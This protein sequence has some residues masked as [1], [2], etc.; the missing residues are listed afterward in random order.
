MMNSVKS[1]FS[2][3]LLLL[4]LQLAAQ[5]PLNLDEIAH[6]RQQALLPKAR[7]LAREFS[8]RRE[9]ALRL[10]K[11]R[12]WVIEEQLP[13]GGVMALQRLDD[14]GMPIYYI[15]HFNTRAAATI[16][17]Q[18]VWP[19]GRSNLNLSGSYPALSER[20]GIW[21]GGSVMHT[22]QEFVDRVIQQEANVVMDNHAT[23]VAGTMMAAGV[24]PLARG[25]AFGVPNIRS[26]SFSNHGD[27]MLGAA[28]SLLVSNHS[29]GQ[30]S[31]WR[32]NSARAG[33]SANP[34]WE[35]WG[36]TRISTTEDYAFGYY[37]EMSMLWDMIAFQSPQYLIVKSAGNNRNQTGP[38]SGAPFWRRNLQ[39]AWELIGMR[40]GEMSSNDGFDIISTYGNAKNILTVAAVNPI[41]NSYRREADVVIS[42]F[43]SFGPSDDGRIKPDISAN[44]VSLYSTTTAGN[45]GYGFMSGTSMS[46]PNVSGSLML[47]Q[48]KYHRLN[49][50]FMLS[51]TLRGLVCHTANE[52]GNP[53]PDYVF[54]WGLMNTERAAQAIQ[55]NGRSSLVEEISLQDGAVITRTVVASGTEPLVV[56]IAWIDPEAIPL[57]IDANALNNR[58]PRLINDLDVR[59]SDGT[60][61]FMPWVLDPN[62][63]SS[64]ATRGDN[65]L[66]NIEQI[67]IASPIPG[68]TYTI[69]ISHKKPT[70][71]RGTKIFSLIATGVGG[72]TVC[73]SGALQQEGARINSVQLG[74][75]NSVT[76]TGCSSYRDL[77]QLSARLSIGSTTP[78]TITTG[79]C[80]VENP[81]I[82]KL[83]ADWNTSGVFDADELV[84][85]SPVINTTGTFSGQIVVPHSAIV[86]SIVRLRVVLRETNHPDLVSA[87]GMFP[88]GETQDF[89]LIIE[90]SLRDIAPLAVTGLENNICARE[91]QLIEIVVDNK[92]TLTA[93]S[94]EAEARITENG[95]L[96]QT[97]TENLPLAVN[98]LS[99]M[100]FRF[101]QTFNTQPNSEYVV[102][103]TTRHTGDA[104]LANNTISHTF[105]TAAIPPNASIEANRCGVQPQVHLRASTDG[106]M[107]WYDRDPS[108]PLVASGNN[109]TLNA[110]PATNRLFGGLNNFVG[111][112]GPV[113]KNS[114]PWTGGTYARATAQPLITTH[115]PLVIE[116]ARLYVGNSG[117]VTFFVENVASGEIV[118]M[119]TLFVTATRTVPTAEVGA[120]DDPDDQGRVYTLNLRIPT[121][122]NY[123]I[124]ISYG[125]G[126]TLFRNNSIAPGANPYP[127]TIPNVIDITGT[128]ATGTPHGFYYWLYD[129]RITALG[130]P[131]ALVEVLPVNR[132]TP[133]VDLEG[134]RAF[135]NG[136]LVL[137]AGNPGSRF[138]WNTNDT[139]QTISPTVPGYYF[140]TVT[141]QWGCQGSGGLNVTVTSVVD[142]HQINAIVYPNPATTTLRVTSPIPVR[143]QL[144][145]S[146]GQSLIAPQQ[147]DTEFTF[148]VAHLQPGLYI[149]RITDIANGHSAQ[150]KIIIR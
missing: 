29:Y 144:F 107:F 149:M 98:G 83:F 122:G 111:R 54:G 116:S 113:T 56:T 45:T 91:G 90:N 94:I 55:N 137:N 120:P 32:F 130:C 92:G 131:A 99:L 129:M 114:E 63:P 125:D 33:T 124:S 16:S 34:N 19:G 25:M 112:L 10:A 37:C 104:N 64:V 106:F 132:P 109:I 42:S 88:A 62:F 118:S 51:S 140:V 8:E 108:G 86:G 39:G 87:C 74:T 24:N 30:I 146:A 150:F 78:F 100:P 46:A 59:V 81:R 75:I 68:K 41:P 138:R 126:T 50:R 5:V 66:D 12:G 58:T 82:I 35:W 44:G 80:T 26:W 133:V 49:Q 97:I 69:T 11:E 40:P 115:V 36:D 67:V 2:L 48:E 1:V 105:R 53:G 43:S 70:L 134:T 141:N 96:L 135:V 76:D 57:P 61:T 14:S 7:E 73:Q 31:G 123:R 147:A 21:D 38:A 128:T 101:R 77:T 47:L 9:Q 119:A 15:T 3:L 110:M 95:V 27:E 23:H 136:Q 85:T 84:A 65:V 71:V 13:E 4:S 22:H 145:N 103:I 89:R 142:P 28:P 52:A 17:T 18:H 6:E 121:P 117:F 127:Y 139:T 79:T 72:T 148:D 60:T 20:L 93:S 143:A 102:T